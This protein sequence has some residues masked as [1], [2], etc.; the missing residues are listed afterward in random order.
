M[1]LAD[2]KERVIRLDPG[3]SENLLL[4]PSELLFMA[5]RPLNI[6]AEEDQKR[7]VEVLAALSEEGRRPDLIV[8]DNCRR[9]REALMRMTTP[10]S[11][12]C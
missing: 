10:R 11:T 8:F 12:R 1:A 7:I 6:N 5:D 9:C 4:L 3:E 2:L